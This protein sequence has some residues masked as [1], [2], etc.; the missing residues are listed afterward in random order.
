MADYLAHAFTAPSAP[1]YASMSHAQL[2]AL[3][4]SLPPND[5]RQAVLAPYE[6]QAFAREWTNENPVIAPISL[7]FAIP[8]YA[9]AKALGIEHAR[10]GPSIA[11]ILAGY[12]G[13]GQ[14]L[15]SVI[16]RRL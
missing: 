5:P 2:L 13:I 6:H 10:T 3:R 1:D 4:N 16:G 11:S 14:G 15:A 12:K 8:G 9:A 7:A